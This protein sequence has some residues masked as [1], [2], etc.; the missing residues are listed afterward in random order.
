MHLEVVK[1]DHDTLE[2]SRL[3]KKID[4]MQSNKVTINI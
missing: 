2:I 3:V 1:V 4:E